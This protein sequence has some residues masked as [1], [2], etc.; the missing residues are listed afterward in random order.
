M[1]L[2]A[3]RR[4]F[5]RLVLFAI[6]GMGT[7]SK[8]G[9]QIW[10]YESVGPSTPPPESQF[11]AVSG[12]CKEGDGTMT[13]DPVVPDGGFVKKDTL[14]KTDVWGFTTGECRRWAW[15]IPQ[16][17]QFHYIDMLRVQQLQVGADPSNPDNWSLTGYVNLYTAAMTYN[18]IPFADSNTTPSPG[19]S[20]FTIGENRFRYKTFASPTDCGFD[21]SSAYV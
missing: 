20:A 5:P 11:R 6:V 15:G 9:A 3:L 1:V 17:S 12:V 8:A 10:T 19:L 13:T 21:T 4:G 14:L 2:K 7:V 18:S 16:E